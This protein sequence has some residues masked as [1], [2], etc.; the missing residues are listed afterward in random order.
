MAVM[1]MG[2]LAYKPLL[3]LIIGLLGMRKPRLPRELKTLVT[4]E[5]D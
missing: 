4:V 3:E 5:L 2:T 1:K